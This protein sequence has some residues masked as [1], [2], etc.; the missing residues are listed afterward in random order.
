M[1]KSKKIAQVDDYCV[2]CG[3]CLKECRFGAIKITNGI[4]AMIDTNLCVGCTKCA[5][6][7]PASSIHMKERGTTD[8]R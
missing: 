5:K 6:I 1:N 4:R 7:C 3:T 2:A 8:E